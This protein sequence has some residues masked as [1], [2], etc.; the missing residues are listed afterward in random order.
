MKTKLLLCLAFGLMFCNEPAKKIEPKPDPKFTK[1][2][3]QK[4]LENGK[5]VAFE[6][7][8]IDKGRL[9]PIKIGMTIAEAEQHLA[10]LTRQDVSSH[11][12]GLDGDS[13]AYMY[14]KGEEPILA[15]IPGMINDTIIGIAAIHKNLKTSNGLTANARVEDLLKTYP[16]IEVIFNQLFFWEDMYDIDKQWNFVFMTEEHNRIGKYPDFEEKS[17]PLRKD[18]KADWILIR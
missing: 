8:V 5:L 16:G 13:D 15:L 4:P 7:F 18:I 17:E 3:E 2:D 9:G 1:P 14:S 11:D 6:D 10:G 12:F